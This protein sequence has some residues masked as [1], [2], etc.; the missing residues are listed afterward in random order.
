MLAGRIVIEDDAVADEQLEPNTRAQDLRFGNDLTLVCI[1]NPH[2]AGA[3][4]RHEDAPDDLD[5]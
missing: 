3:V 2:L 5:G 1:H 4:I